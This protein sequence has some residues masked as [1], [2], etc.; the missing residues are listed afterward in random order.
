MILKLFTWQFP[1]KRGVALRCNLCRSQDMQTFHCLIPWLRPLQLHTIW[2]RWSAKD[3]GLMKLGWFLALLLSA[4]L[5]SIHMFE[6]CFETVLKTVLQIWQIWCKHRLQ[7]YAHHTMTVG[8]EDQI[9]LARIQNRLSKT[10]VTQ[11]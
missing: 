11:P 4:L 5:C 6:N 10:T 9:V 8:L 1:R 3:P 2:W 7:Y